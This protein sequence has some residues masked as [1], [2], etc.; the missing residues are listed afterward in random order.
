MLKFLYNHN[1]IVIATCIILASFLVAFWLYPYIKSQKKL[2][3]LGIT[4]CTSS[5]CD[6]RPEEVTVT[7]FVGA[8]EIRFKVY[9]EK[10]I[11]L[12][13][14]WSTVTDV[15]LQNCSNLDSIQ[16][17]GIVTNNL[18]EGTLILPLTPPVLNDNYRFMIKG[19]SHLRRIYNCYPI[20]MMFEYFDLTKE[21]KDLLAGE[22]SIVYNNFINALDL[23]VMMNDL[24]SNDVKADLNQDGLVNSL[25]LSNQ[26]YNFY[27]FGE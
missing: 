6:S 1:W 7:A 11:P 23:S 9:P 25:D 18:G 20:S 26:I 17:N 12:V 5:P 27:D 13:N 8:K 3:I 24:F 19:L 16:F 2:Q 10:R 14:N 22:I 4:I 21:N 15:T